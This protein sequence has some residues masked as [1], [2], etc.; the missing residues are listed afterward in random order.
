MR[1]RLFEDH[2]TEDFFSISVHVSDISIPLKCARNICLSKGLF[3][4]AS[5][6]KC[7]LEVYYIIF[8]L[9]HLVYVLWREAPS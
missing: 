1:E 7:S 3:W 5:F 8:W 9:S 4:L 2:S 6:T